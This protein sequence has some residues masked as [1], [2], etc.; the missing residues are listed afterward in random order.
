[1]TLFGLKES[2]KKIEGIRIG[3]KETDSSVWNEGF[4]QTLSSG[5]L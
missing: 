3:G 5:I 2:H 4:A 1:M